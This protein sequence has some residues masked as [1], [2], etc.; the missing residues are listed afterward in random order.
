MGITPIC[1]S[2]FTMIVMSIDR[3][4]A[5]VY[6]LRRRPGKR[7]TITIIVCIW[8]LAI[9]CGIPAL[10]ATKIEQ[11]FFVNP[12]DINVFEDRLCLAD[13]FPDGDSQTS[14]L[15]SIYNNSLV[16]MQYLIPLLILSF[17]ECES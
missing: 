1:A 15:F 5:V 4:I 13:R 8:I 6:P 12:N 2:V 10:A 9:L 14:I 11:H 7:K 17:T 16:I 3:Y